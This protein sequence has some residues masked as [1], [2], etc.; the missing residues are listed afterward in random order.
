MLHSS[1][2]L[3]P[4]IGSVP[5]TGALGSGGVLVIGSGMNAADAKKRNGS[6]RRNGKNA[7]TGSVPAKDGSYA[8]PPSLKRAVFFLL[9]CHWVG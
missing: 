9:F 2:I 3:Y 1:F 5:V 8:P 6:W 7:R 4:F